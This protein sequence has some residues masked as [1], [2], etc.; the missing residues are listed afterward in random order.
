MNRL[1]PFASQVFILMESVDQENKYPMRISLKSHKE[2]FLKKS[3]LIVLLISGEI[4][5]E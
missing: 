2:I 5:I 1:Y 4:S 3:P